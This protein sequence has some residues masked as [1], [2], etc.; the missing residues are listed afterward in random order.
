MGPH[1]ARLLTLASW[2]TGTE[3]N[4]SFEIPPARFRAVRAKAVKVSLDPDGYR[5]VD[6]KFTRIND[7]ERIRSV[8]LDL[9]TH[10]GPEQGP[11]S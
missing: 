4:L 2:E 8:L 10:K 7:V 1:E 5:Q 11:G 6:L 3:G 9:E